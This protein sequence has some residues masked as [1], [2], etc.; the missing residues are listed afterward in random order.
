M[1]SEPGDTGETL[2]PKA[3]LFQEAPASVEG[4]VGGFNDKCRVLP[5]KE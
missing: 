3:F 1:R 5:K 2:P 4:W